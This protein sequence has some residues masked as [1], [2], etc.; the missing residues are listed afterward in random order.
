[1]VK[2]G[3]RG[4]RGAERGGVGARVGMQGVMKK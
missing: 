1:M 4:R 3:R 2:N